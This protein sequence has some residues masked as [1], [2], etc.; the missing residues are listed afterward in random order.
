MVEVLCQFGKN[1]H[2][3]CSSN[4][5]GDPACADSTDSSHSHMG[6]TRPLPI[7]AS[8]KGLLSAS[9]CK[10]S[11]SPLHLCC[12]I[13]HVKQS[14]S[15]F[16]MERH[17]S[18]NQSSAKIIPMSAKYASK[19]AACNKQHFLTPSNSFASNLPRICAYRENAHHCCF[20]MCVRWMHSQSMH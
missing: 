8:C 10:L 20:S 4:R 9:S 14:P 6:L 16:G 3:C 19:F 13:A 12:T 2:L 11:A 7:K 1:I 5:L 17:L 18:N 15:T